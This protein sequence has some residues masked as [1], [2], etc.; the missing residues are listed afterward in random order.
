MKI[1]PEQEFLLKILSS[2]VNDIFNKI[3]V[4]RV[5]R[6]RTLWHRIFY[7]VNS[8]STSG[9]VVTLLNGTCGIGYMSL[10]L[11]VSYFGFGLGIFIIIL[12][13][14]LSLSS[15]NILYNSI[16]ISKKKKAANI[17]TYFLGKKASK[18]FSLGIL[19]VQFLYLFSIL[20]IL[21]NLS[22][23]IILSLTLKTKYEEYPKKLYNEPNSF[24]SIIIRSAIF[25]IILFIILLPFGLKRNHQ[26]AR[27][28]SFTNLIIVIYFEGCLIYQSADYL[29][30]HKSM[31][32]YSINLNYK[33]P[34]FKWS[35]GL[36]IILM[37]FTCHPS[38]FYVDNDYKNLAKYQVQK[39]MSYAT[40]IETI[41]YVLLGGVGY[42]TFGDNYVSTIFLLR[43]PTSNFFYLIFF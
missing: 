27:Y 7:P 30:M 39:V 3:Q 41:T 43:E 2:K 36:S 25:F 35:L 42:Y 17:C 21:W 32:T 23:N 13:G 12:G 19:G 10:P 6:G 4:R 24:D 29:D 34:C 11:I 1:I 40:L 15:M 5:D 9:S 20:A 26:F 31:D 16:L 28:I 18:A 37:C 8:N 14:L 22:L 38:Y 33:K